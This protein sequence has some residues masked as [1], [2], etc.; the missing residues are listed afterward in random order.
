MPKIIYLK[1]AKGT[2]WIVENKFIGKYII[3][4]NPY[5]A[6]EDKISDKVWYFIESALNISYS[7]AIR[8]KCTLNSKYF[9]NPKE[10]KYS[11]DL[12]IIN[13]NLDLK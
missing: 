7:K 11:K 9:I 2:E 5:Q 12:E 3:D 8:K 1:S 10:A 13:D 4:K 6:L